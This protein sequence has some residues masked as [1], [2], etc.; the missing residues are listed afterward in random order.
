MAGINELLYNNT[1]EQP[2]PMLTKEDVKEH[3]HIK[4]DRSF[5]K[6]INEQ[7][8]PYIKI[9]RKYL[10]PLKKYNQWLKNMMLV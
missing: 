7:Q 5:Y 10:V 9:G 8:L 3:L 1:T 4:D 2:E 6:L